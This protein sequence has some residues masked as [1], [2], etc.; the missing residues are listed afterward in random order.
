MINMNRKFEFWLRNEEENIFI[1]LPI[2]P[3]MYDITYGQKIEIVNATAIGDINITGHR[4]P[5]SLSIESFFPASD[6]EYDF[7]N[8]VTF[9]ATD[10]MDYVNKI[11]QWVDNKSIIRCIVTDSLSSK[12]NTLF[13]VENI[14]FWE[15][16]ESN[17]DINYVISLREY[18][19]MNTV[20]TSVGKTQNASRTVDNPPSKPKSYTV[21][22][23]DT[24]SGIS[25]RFYGT[26]NKWGDIYNANKSV[27]GKNPNLIFPG[28]VY[29]IP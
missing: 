15:D 26:P 3:K 23:G 22:K 29:Q 21:V 2:T 7:V 19:P 5:M 27:I 1:L 13:Y 18:R 28:Q 8:R 6:S 25:R 12:I 17:G 10:A 14:R 20:K 11:K 16:D 4:E 9:V 24:L